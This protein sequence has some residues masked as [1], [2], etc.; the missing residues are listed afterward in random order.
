MVPR[1]SLPA[2]TRALAT[3]GSGFGTA[4]IR[5]DSHLPAMAA[6]S[7][8]RLT[9]G[10]LSTEQ[11]TMGFDPLGEIVD[12]VNGSPLVS[13]RD[14]QGAGNAGQRFRYSLDQKRFPAL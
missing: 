5:N 2:M 12:T 9:I 4:W 10:L 8:R 1:L 13:S 6:V 3:P 7:V 14:D 11:I